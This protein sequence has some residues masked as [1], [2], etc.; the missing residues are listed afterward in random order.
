MLD[1]AYDPDNIFAKILR[2]EMACARVFEDE[3]VFSFMDVFPQSRGHTLVIPKH[4][5]ARNLLEEE[6][7]RLSHLILGVQRVAKAV[8]AA[9]NPDGLVITQFN[10]APAGQ[11]IYHLHVH[12]IP[13]WEG[14]PVG[15]H[16][17][18]GMADMDELKALAEQ[19]SAKIS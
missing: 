7:E 13:R 2:G 11:T 4:T 15:R 10:G 5:T 6:P 18:G 12:I 17:S 9:L 16:A 1:G 19:I 3:H 14:V 8:R